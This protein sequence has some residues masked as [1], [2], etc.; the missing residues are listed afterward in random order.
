LAVMWLTRLAARIEGRAWAPLDPYYE[1][2]GS[3]AVAWGLTEHA[4]NIIN[5][6]SMK[7]GGKEIEPS[8]PVSLN[9]K[10]D[11]FRKSHVRLAYLV[12][13]REE[14]LAIVDEIRALKEDRHALIHGIFAGKDASGGR[15]LSM[16][17]IK[18]NGNAISFTLVSYTHA[19]GQEIQAKAWALTERVVAHADEIIRLVSKDQSNDLEG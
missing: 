19:G 8:L 2:I 9:R 3:V 5:A 11:F 4:L 17:K 7:Y 15:E 13:L 16:P 14:G 12:P 18:K 10:I 1:L 6:F